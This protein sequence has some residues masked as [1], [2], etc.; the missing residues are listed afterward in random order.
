MT[1]PGRI[2]A[3]RALLHLDPPD[4]FLR[5]ARGVAEVAAW[6]A[7]RA[8]ARG[9]SLD[10]SLVESAALL[11][12]VDKLLPADDPARSLPHGHGSAAWLERRGYVPLAAAVAAHPVTRLAEPGAGA[13]LRTAPP[14]ELIVAY[15]DKRI[16]QRLVS[17]DERFA[18]WRRRDP[19]SPFDAARMRRLAGELE[20]LV[21]DLAAVAPDHVGRLAWT[22][23]ALRRARLASVA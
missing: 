17:L 7:A 23:P 10:R 20:T 18:S 21:C 9:L 14:A 16:G 8:A 5:H 19:D 1:I 15:A 4:W 22:G 2:E 3:A 13:W 6:L 12:D 11:H